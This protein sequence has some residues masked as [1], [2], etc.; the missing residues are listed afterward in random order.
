MISVRRRIYI[1]IYL[2]YTYIKTHCRIF[3]VVIKMKII[4]TVNL[5]Q[6]TLKP[7][8][9]NNYSTI[10]T[11]TFLMKLGNAHQWGKPH[12]HCLLYNINV[13]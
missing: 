4:I 2:T 13:G 6:S 5:V 3:K 10:G 9:S 11:D 8:K 12:D 1:Y 7:N